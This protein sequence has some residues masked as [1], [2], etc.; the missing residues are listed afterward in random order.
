MINRIKSQKKSM[1]H[2]IK[3]CLTVIIGAV[4][5]SLLISFFVKPGQVVGHSMDT[6]LAN[7]DLVVINK[8]SYSSEAPKYK[9]ILVL[10]SNVNGGEM[11]IKRVIGVPGDTIDIKDNQLFING[12]IMDEKYI[13]EPMVGNNDMEVS[14]PKGKI[15]VMGDNRNNSLDSRSLILGV[16]DYKKDVIGKVCFRIY[17]FNSISF[18]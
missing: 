4:I 2:T 17:P 7:N 13:K 8:L 1:L 18:L 16:V 6:T 5:L 3:E 15:F 12:K 14:V 9:D 10:N 11:L